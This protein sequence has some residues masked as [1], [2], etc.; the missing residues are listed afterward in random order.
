MKYDINAS[1]FEEKVHKLKRHFA[2]KDY[3]AMF[4]DLGVELEKLTADFSN[5]GARQ[6]KEYAA[7]YAYIQHLTT[8][9]NKRN[10]IYTSCF[11]NDVKPHVCAFRD[12]VFL[13]FWQG[14]VMAIIKNHICLFPVDFARF[15]YSDAAQDVGATIF[16]VPT[17]KEAKK[18]FDAICDN[19]NSQ[20]LDFESFL[21]ECKLQEKGKGLINS[22][23]IYADDSLPTA[24]VLAKDIASDNVN[25]FVVKFDNDTNFN[26]SSIALKM[27]NTMLYR[28]VIDTKNKLKKEMYISKYEAMREAFYHSL[29]DVFG[30]YQIK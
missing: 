2:H 10:I 7:R 27:A 21:A 22:T 15:Q 16:H 25:L 3:D 12:G 18:V 26:L 20:T 29:L 6:S 19:S 28:F 11:V 24:F 13:G 14:N 8:H 9:Y 1:E 4:K 23:L 5:K 30:Q 17:T